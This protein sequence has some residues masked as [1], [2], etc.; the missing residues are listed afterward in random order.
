M[1]ILYRHPYIGKDLAKIIWAYKNAHFPLTINKFT[2]IQ[3]IP[4]ETSV[5]LTPYLIFR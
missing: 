1:A 4:H 2:E 3:G 5:K